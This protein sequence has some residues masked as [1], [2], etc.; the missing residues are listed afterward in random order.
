MIKEDFEKITT[1]LEIRI[2]A[3]E[4][5]LGHIKTT[6]D[7]SNIT[8]K[9]LAE[10]R[11]FC[12][13]EVGIMTQIAM[14]DFYH[15]IGMGNLTAVQEA[16]FVKRMK[17][18]LRYRPNVKHLAKELDNLNLDSLPEIPA[19][20]K[21]KLMALCD[22]TLFSSKAAQ[23]DA[24]TEAED[25]ESIEDY[26]TA[27]AE[28]PD[29]TQFSNT[30]TFRDLAIINFTTKVVDIQDTEK[31]AAKMDGHYCFDKEKFF[32]A[33]ANGGKYFGL[34]FIRVNEQRV[35]G[36]AEKDAQLKNIKKLLETE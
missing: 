2:G 31:F 24:N 20:T 16:T 8:V 28:V 21:F 33:I 19:K 3:C 34:S 35:I 13:R 22:L 14:V 10:L 18:Y 32:T 27:K 9:D 6:E 4:Q 5:Y 25:I 11:L 17:Q 30:A 15:V 29:A 12:K 1:A 23:D 36:I 7:L 26:Q